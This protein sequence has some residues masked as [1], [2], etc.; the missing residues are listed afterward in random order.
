MDSFERDNLGAL[1]LSDAVCVSVHNNIL[2]LVWVPVHRTPELHSASSGAVELKA[3]SVPPSCRANRFCDACAGQIVKPGLC[4]GAE[5]AVSNCTTVTLGEF[6]ASAAFDSPYTC[7]P[8]KVN[9]IKSYSLVV[10]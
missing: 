10:R 1:E 3:N 4:P 5:L 9:P 8:W 2:R 7:A 6:A